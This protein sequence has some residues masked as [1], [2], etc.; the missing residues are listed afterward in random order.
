MWRRIGL[1]GVAGVCAIVASAGPGLAEGPEISGY[2]EPEVRYFVEEGSDPAQ[3]EYN[4]SVSADV[5]LEWE[6]GRDRQLVVNPFARLDQNDPNRTHFDL[7][8]A[9]YLH[10][11][12]NDWE[13]RIGVDRV[14]WGVT[15]AAHLIDVINQTDQVEDVDDESA[16]GQPLV[17][18][19][20]PSD[21]GL[22]EA[23]ILPY[24]RERTFASRKGRP[25]ADLLVDDDNPAYE[26]AAQEWH[27][28]FAVRWSNF[29][30]PVDVGVSHF[31]G[32]GRD[33]ILR[34]VLTGGELKLQPFY[35][36][37][38]QTS[39][40]FQATI[41]P[42]LYKFEG[43]TRNEY[44]ERYYAA[45]GGIEYTL[46]QVLDTDGDLG[47]VAEYIYDSRGRNGATTPF[48]NDVFGGLRWALNNEA[49]STVLAGAIV[50]VESGGMSIGLEA[51][52]RFREDY[53]I[54][55]E[56][57]LFSSIASDDLLDS[58]S[59]DGFLQLRVQRF[60]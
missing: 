12:P 29:F 20:I 4:L 50:D 51:E 14:F 47:I 39:V 53:F 49:S 44:G 6:W 16:L 32:T 17:K 10:V 19:A 1:A 54:S 2:I 36:Q 13:I 56:A 46:F 7:R 48:A 55:F 40:D 31:S 25:R 8:E 34:P 37:I 60:F 15:E 24:F 41:G 35:V 58:T 45:T 38:D 28:D 23:Y 43:F 30:G 3:D 11:F 42:T 9:K 26:S 33:P 22:F 59:D 5:E 27:T 21:I 18:L 52:T 57:R